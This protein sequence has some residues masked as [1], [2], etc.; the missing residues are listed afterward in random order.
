MR[1]TEPTTMVTDYILAGMGIFFGRK[2]FLRGK[3]INQ[4]SIRLWAVSF[5]AMAVGA[6]AGGTSHGFANY[7]GDLGQTITWK[8][9]VYAIGVASVCMASAAIHAHFTGLPRRVLLVVVGIK[10]LVYAFWMLNHD[11][12]EYVINDYAPTMLF[13]FL[14][15]CWGLITRR[16][17]SAPWII[18]GIAVSFVGAA[19]QQNE[20]ALHQ[21]FNHND[22]YHVIQMV[23]LY[24]LYR[25]GLLLRDRGGPLE[26]RR[27]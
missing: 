7:L 11:D 2:L 8:L 10:F 16:A 1:I 20:I 19:I 5:I 17:K 24:L 23:G 6:L 21:H 26:I 25:G 13:V 4:Q 12:F 18:A 14:L 15:E 3:E 9:T 27:A 22:L